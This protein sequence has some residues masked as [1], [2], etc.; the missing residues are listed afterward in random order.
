[1]RILVIE[2]DAESARWLGQA[3][4]QHGHSVDVAGN[5]VDGLA[6]ARGGGYDAAVIDRMLPRLDGLALVR[7]LRQERVALPILLLTA[8]A[9]TRERVEGLEAGADDYLGKPFAFTELHARLQALARRPP[10]AQVET[11]L[12]AGDLEMDLL[13]RSVTRAGRRIELQA[14]EFQLLEYLLRHVDRVVTRTMLLEH[15]WEFHFDPKT[16]VVETHISRLRAKV[17]RGHAQKLI[18]TVRG[19]GYC[20]RAPD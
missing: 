3:L 12:R 18:Q 2:D 6:L 14:R 15:V 4:R 7:T 19:V 17:D 9:E 20:L 8:L 16:S 1:M 13:R 11:L 5:G 10:L